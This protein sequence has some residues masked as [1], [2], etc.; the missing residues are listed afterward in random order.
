MPWM[1]WLRSLIFTFLSDK[2]ANDV[3]SGRLV[4]ICVIFLFGWKMEF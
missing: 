3:F 2:M 4:L 1:H